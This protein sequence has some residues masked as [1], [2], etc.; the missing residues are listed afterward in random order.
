MKIRKIVLPLICFM[1][2]SCGSNNST[3]P[4]TP[5]DPPVV[6][7]DD[8]KAEDEDPVM[9]S[10]VITNP[11]KTTYYVGDRLDLTGMTVK[12]KYSDNSEMQIS[13]NNCTITG[14][15]STEPAQNQ[16][17]TVKYASVSATFKVNI[18]EQEDEGDDEGEED[19]PAPVVTLSSISVTPPTKTT[20]EVGDSLVLT[21]MVVTA[22]YSDSSTKTISNSDVSVTGFNSASAVAS[23]TLTVTY[24]GKTATFTVTINKKEEPPVVTLLDPRNEPHIGDQYYLNNIGDIYAVWEK[25]RGNGV[26]IAVID[27]NFKPTHED[28]YYKDGTSKVSNKSAS[29]TVSGNNVITN[30][31]ASY[32]VNPGNSGESHGTFCAGVAAAAVNGKGVAGIAPDAELM[33]LRTDAKVKSINEAFKYAADN[34]AKVITISIGS[35][36]GGD[37]D[38][39]E[40]GTDLTTAFD[41]AVAYCR[42]KGV[43]VCSAAGNGGPSQANKPTEYT[44]PGA[45][46]GVI[47]VGGLAR[48]ESAQVWDGSSYNYVSPSGAVSQFVDVMAPADG[49]YGCSHYDS[50]NYD[51]GWNGTSFASPIVAGMAA[52]Y[53][54]K[55]PTKTGSDFEADLYASCYKMS[56]DSSGTG[57][58]GYGRVDVA[59]LLGE[60]VSQNVTVKL[61]ANWTNAYVYAYDNAHTKENTDW[62]G[63]KMTKSGNTFICTVNAAQ[64]E[65]LLFSD[66]NNSRKSVNLLTSSFLNGHTYNLSNSPVFDNIYTGNYQ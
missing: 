51:G 46:T 34:G 45:T 55:Y 25:Y 12:V 52:L 24:Q 17:I 4:V 48:N 7:P 37:G 63:V 19:P 50:K 42:N 13:V 29:F 32:A 38:L 8:G 36:N 28:F 26:T 64:Y 56:D 44:Y 58:Y 33:L 66:G 62:P 20:Y 60:K 59:R 5:V 40:K 49:M 10:L 23:Q 54:E 30:V 6:D 41:S 61:N 47:G 1:L 53:F 65:C 39:D 21:G 22:R 3:T 11:T 15:N 16:V 27:V 35:Y 9:T 43:V 31:G 14:F 18:I 2:F 57:K